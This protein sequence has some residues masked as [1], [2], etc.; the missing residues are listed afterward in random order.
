MGWDGM[1]WVFE[2]GRK[3]WPHR[4]APP[5]DL[6]VGVWLAFLLDAMAP[7]QDVQH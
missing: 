2:M 6:D 4:T 3:K 1:A 7:S 5:M